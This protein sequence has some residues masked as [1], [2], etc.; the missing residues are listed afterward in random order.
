MGGKPSRAREHLY[1]CLAVLIVVG[2]CGIVKGNREVKTTPAPVLMP[3]PKPIKHPKVVIEPPEV[4]LRREANEHLAK[5][6]HLL[7]R[8]DYD[9]ALRENEEA[10]F[11]AKDR[12]PADA[13]VFYM[14]LIYAHPGNPKKD[15]RRAIGFFNRVVKTHPESMWAEQ[16]KIWVAVLDGV[17]KLKQVDLEIEEKKRDRPR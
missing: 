2:G 17:E 4:R 15:N 11:V 1:I 7:S 3:E 14:G 6:R 13:A 5:A 8:G 10:L 12:S 16:A 9:A